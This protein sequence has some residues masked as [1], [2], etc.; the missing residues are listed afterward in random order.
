MARAPEVR[1]VSICTKWKNSWQ[2]SEST[3]RRATATTTRRRVEGDAE[4]TQGQGVRVHT[5]ST[6]VREG[7]AAIAHVVGLRALGAVAQKAHRPVHG[8][9]QSAYARA[10][11][12]RPLYRCTPLSRA[13]A[14]GAL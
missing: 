3:S 8:A 7:K 10:R 6:G 12:R 5:A 13:R 9:Q 4:A 11:L 2:L 1:R 14:A